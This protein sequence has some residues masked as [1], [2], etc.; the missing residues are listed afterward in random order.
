VAITRRGV[1]HWYLKDKKD[2]GIK[3]VDFIEFLE[4]LFLNLAP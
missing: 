1:E 2:E 4:R 3:S